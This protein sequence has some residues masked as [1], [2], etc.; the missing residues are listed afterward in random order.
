MAS[1]VNGQQNGQ[2]QYVFSNLDRQYGG[3]ETCVLELDKDNVSICT[4]NVNIG[5]GAI[6]VANGEV[7]IPSMQNAGGDLRGTYPSP[8]VKGLE[9]YE[10]EDGPPSNGDAI[11]FDGAL[12]KWV[13]APIVFGGGPPVGPAGGDLDGVYPDPSLAT[14]G[15]GAVTKGAADKVA[16]VTTD[17]KGRVST[18]TE[19]SIQIAQ[20]QVNDLTTDL[21]AKVDDTVQVIA[22]TGLS[23]GGTL[24]SNVTVSMPNVGPGVVTK[25]TASKSATVTLDAQGRVTALSD[26]DISISESQV[27]GL[28]GDLA[29]KANNT[30]TI[31][32]G[33]GL[34]GGGDLSA[35]RTIS[36]PNVGPGVV[37]KGSS[38][39]SAVVTTD[40]QGRITSLTET[41]I[42]FPTSLPPSGSAGGSLAGTYPN[43]TIA[44]SGVT[45]NTYTNATVTVAADGRI[46]SASSGTA[47]V[48]SVGATAPISSSGGTTPTISLNDVSPSPAGTYGSATSVPVVTVDSKGRTTSVTNTPITFPAA[49]TSLSP[50]LGNIAIVDSVNGNDSTAAVNGL[51]FSTVE[52]GLAAVAAAGSPST[53][54]IMPGTYTLASATTGLTMPNG[55]TMRGHNTQTTRILMNASNA[56]NT[57]TLLTMGENSR[58]EDLNLQLNSSNATTNLVGIAL[59]GSTSI[60]SK[61]RTGVLTVNNSGLSAGTS[62]N[63]TGILS[64]GS[65]TLGNADFS[66]NFT[67][68][69]TV[70][71]YSNGGGN[72]RGILVSAANA[73]TFRD[74]NIYVAEPPDVTSNGSYVGVESADVL[75]SVQFRTS[76]IGSAPFLTS[77]TKLPVVAAATT[78]ITL[79]GTYTLQGVA[80]TSGMQ[81][82][83]AGQT[84]G[85]NNGIWVVDS[86]AWTRAADMLSGSSSLNARTRVYGG[87]YANTT[88]T[89]TTNGTVGTN[90][91]T[92]VQLAYTGSDILQT[93][94]GTGFINNGVQI[95]PG[96]DLVN[97]TAGDKPLTT[98]VTPTIL[99]MGL[100]GNVDSS[101]H[102]MWPG[103]LATNL[104]A[105]EVFYRIQQK[106]IVQGM[107][108]TLR[109]PPGTG[110]TMTV[111]IRR[112]ST[113]IDGSGFPTQMV[114]TLSGTNKLGT[115]YTV[116]E[117]FQ[118]GEFLSVQVS[119][120]AGMTSADL[121]VEIDI[122]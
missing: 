120:T 6:V 112:S 23:G 25:G 86:G 85:V 103:T 77:N 105:T 35:N 72:K 3:K 108:I 63:V 56:G 66:F 44:N 40:A 8:E 50:K 82:L 24:S 111:S 46:T 20:S 2:G 115:Q 55:C 69:V 116:S 97:K 121:V 58:V 95:G 31:S 30:V 96:C 71:V 76:S 104:D 119:G 91:L 83:A 22:G 47:P 94:P 122:F 118:T 57:V 42:A 62:T 87:T 9:G 93:T 10:I 88:W 102:Y 113:G 100:K 36:M 65:G 41:S 49:P 33:T 11:L 79:S 53:L 59:P 16:V 52:A 18:L 64:N 60:T 117:N 78:N 13:H 109:T 26:Q 68:G 48:T 99:T 90:A 14:F 114:A 12:N 17:T 106:A 98:Y 4:P 51:P 84:S 5:Q 81:V 7:I 61:F 74:T 37:T 75:C 110:K 67:R 27:S 15:P 39:Q 80:L 54:W 38:T 45:A 29:A 70:N 43:P 1:D 34:S 28:T 107:T 21:A 101:A 92:F 32:A 89:C 19:T 73:I